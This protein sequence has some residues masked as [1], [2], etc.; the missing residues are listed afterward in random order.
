MYK[1]NYCTT[2]YIL[3]YIMKQYSIFYKFNYWNNVSYYMRTGE[4]G[5]RMNI[6]VFF[7]D[8][9]V[10]QYNGDTKKDC[11]EQAKQRSKKLD[12]NICSIT[13]CEDDGDY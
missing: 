5:D 4:Q 7:D 9:E 8:D 10:R 1:L 11:L 12:V 2:V 6:I 13:V 3:G